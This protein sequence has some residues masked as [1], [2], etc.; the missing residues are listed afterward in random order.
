MGAFEGKHEVAA[1]ID[2]VFA[3]SQEGVSKGQ[4]LLAHAIKAMKL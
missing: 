2:R 1:L 3:S 4:G